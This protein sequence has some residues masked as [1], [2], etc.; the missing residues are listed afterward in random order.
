M[1]KSS[2]GCGRTY[3]WR[4]AYA[5]AMSKSSIGLRPEAFLEIRLCS[6]DAEI[7]RGAATRSSSRNTSAFLRGLRW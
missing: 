4:Y 2:K 5:P 1:L 6:C 3:F 7:K